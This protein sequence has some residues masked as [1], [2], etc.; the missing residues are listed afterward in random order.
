MCIL[1]ELTTYLDSPVSGTLCSISLNPYHFV[2]TFVYMLIYLFKMCKYIG[3]K[4]LHN[5]VLLI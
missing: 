4:Q 2:L 3:T 1:Q 5:W